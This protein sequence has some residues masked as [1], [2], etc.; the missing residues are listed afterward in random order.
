M[1]NIPILHIR[2]CAP[3]HSPRTLAINIT[4]LSLYPGFEEQTTTWKGNRQLFC[5]AKGRLGWPLLRQSTHTSFAADPQR[6]LC[7]D[8]MK[9]C[10]F[11]MPEA[12]ERRSSHRIQRSQRFNVKASKISQVREA[13]P[14]GPSKDCG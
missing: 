2:T 9:I 12:K 4:C 8:Q 3:P 7:K 10:P 6:T 13:R 5:G 11:I 14:N 1:A